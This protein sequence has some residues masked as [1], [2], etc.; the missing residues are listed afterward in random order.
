MMG[1]WRKTLTKT[2]TLE[3]KIVGKL[4]KKRTHKRFM[5]SSNKFKTCTQPTR[6]FIKESRIGNLKARYLKA[7]IKV[8]RKWATVLLRVM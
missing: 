4:N 8:Q 3:T 7:V 5:K 1:L 6:M 2:L